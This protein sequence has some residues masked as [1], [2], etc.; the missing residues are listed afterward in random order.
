MPHLEV[1]PVEK[2][3]WVVQYEGDSTPLATFDNKEDAVAEAR[4]HAREF[5][6]PIIRVYGLDTEVETMII[7]PDHLG[8]PPHKGFGEAA[9]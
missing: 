3:K 8:T 1:L 6:E 2:N 7:E 4:N 9:Y 5:P